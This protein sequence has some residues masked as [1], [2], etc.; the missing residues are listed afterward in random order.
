ML[1]RRTTLALAAASMLILACADAPVA[2]RAASIT[3]VDDAS[4]AAA[5]GG[6]RPRAS[7]S[8]MLTQTIGATTIEAVIRVTSLALSEEGT[9]LASGVITGT[10]NGTQ[11]TQSFTDVPAQLGSSSS[12]AMA[13]AADGPEIMQ[14][15]GGCPIL[16]LDLGPLTLDI[17]GLVVDLSAVSLDIVAQ[18]GA[19]NLLGNLLCAIVSL[20]DGPA[21][22]AAVSNLLEQV[23][24]IIGLL[25]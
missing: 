10:A 21:L 13:A 1:F 7:L 23:N 2:P 17:L 14:I 3:P 18:P 24:T 12:S 4:V 5:R 16:L 22:F 20:L 19:G 6:N 11:F 9:L 25:G 8:G 15:E